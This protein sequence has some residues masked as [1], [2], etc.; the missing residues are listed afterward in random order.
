MS[1]S[2][3]DAGPERWLAALA[4]LAICVIS[5]GNVVVRYATDASFAFTEEFSVFLLVVLTFSGAAL[6]SRRHTHIRI[7]LIE[8]KL[9]PRLRVVLYLLQWAASVL[10]LA[11]VVWYGGLLTWEEYSWESLSPG[12]GYPTWIYII[13]LPLLCL[14]IIWRLTQS[15]L[16]RSR[17]CLKEQT[18]ES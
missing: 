11:L 17:A 5:L 1:R 13:W 4:L 14:A 3:P 6:A 12:L 15:V 18:H 10:L 2:A 9:P 16:A 8:N 7:E